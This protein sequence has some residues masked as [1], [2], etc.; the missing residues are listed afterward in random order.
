[1]SILFWVGAGLSRASG[2]PAPP[3]YDFQRFLLNQE[4]CWSDYL[5]WREQVLSCQPNRGHEILCQLQRTHRA[6]IVT[7]NQDGLLQRAGCQ[8]LELHGNAF[9]EH[10][11][12]AARRPGVVW[13]G[14]ELDQALVRQ[15]LEWVE[16]SEKVVVVG[17]S[18]L[19]QPVCDFPLQRTGRLIEVNLQETPLSK[20]CDEC[21]RG[22]AEKL[23]ERFLEP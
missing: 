18:S 21:W 6:R 12:G 2:V 7:L 10:W 13:Q 3:G 15:A 23:L 8:V 16:G 22:R 14:E 20:H 19:L 5:A 17:S 1:M 4:Q 11:S 9:A